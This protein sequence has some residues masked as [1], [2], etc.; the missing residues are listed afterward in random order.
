MI[1]QNI[2]QNLDGRVPSGRPLVPVL[3]PALELLFDKAN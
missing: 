1:Q 2:E 3:R